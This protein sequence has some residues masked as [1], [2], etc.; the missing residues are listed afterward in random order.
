MGASIRSLRRLSVFA[1]VVASLGM[2]W[3]APP[4]GAV[5]PPWAG[6][7]GSGTPSAPSIDICCAWSEGILDGITYRIVG[8]TDQATYDAINDGVTQWLDQVT[9]SRTLALVEVDPSDAAEVTI[10]F[11]R[12]GGN[13]QGTTSRSSD[14]SGFVTGAAIKIQAK[15]FGQ[16][17]EAVAL[18]QISAHE[19]GHALGLNHA[20]VNGKMMSPTLTGGS[21]TITACDSGALGDAQQWFFAGAASPASPTT[22]PYEC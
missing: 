21:L 9:G 20:N 2:G 22:D 5:P 14:G 19:F 17:N 10:T 13:I 16:A 18:Q 11:K 7:P 15:A 8:T 4:A 12:G 3:A 1:V 6:P